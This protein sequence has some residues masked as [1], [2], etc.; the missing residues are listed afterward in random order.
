[1]P[2]LI[3]LVHDGST[4]ADKAID[5]AIKLARDRSKGLY[6]LAISPS[7]ERATASSKTRTSVQL[8]DLTEFAELSS[9]F[10]IAV[11]GGHI[12]QPTES[13][14]RSFIKSHHVVHVVMASDQLVDTSSHNGRFL[15]AF[16]RSCPVP[17]S[18]V[19]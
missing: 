18:I 15:S 2:E 4:L 3:L 19:P 17:V 10:G 9:K 8:D 14:L 12:V 13:A 16:A 7:N 5:V 6:L 11:A 1:M